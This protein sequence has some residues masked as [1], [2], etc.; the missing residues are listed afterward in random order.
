MTSSVL[1]WRQ[2]QLVFAGERHCW[3][4]EKQE[5]KLELN[6]LVELLLENFE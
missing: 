2:S 5:A 4:T 6:R 3:N 1:N